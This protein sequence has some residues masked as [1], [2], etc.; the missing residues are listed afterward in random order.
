MPMF[1]HSI[2]LPQ[3]VLVFCIYVHATMQHV[4][5]RSVMQ[6]PLCTGELIKWLCYGELQSY[7]YRRQVSGALIILRWF[8]ACNRHCAI[9]K[10]FNPEWMGV[11]QKPRQSI[12]TY[13]PWPHIQT[14]ELHNLQCIVTSRR[15][16]VFAHVHNQ[17]ESNGQK[18]IK[19]AVEPFIRWCTHK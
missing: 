5:R 2:T 18:I 15:R 19:V 14:V 12:I 16:S 11:D 9:A 8:R 7:V 10:H 3:I 1:C 6:F 4:V 13:I 17:T